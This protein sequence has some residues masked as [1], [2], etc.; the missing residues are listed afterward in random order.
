M[1]YLRKFAVNRRASN[2]VGHPT[3]L[4]GKSPGPFVPRCASSSANFILVGF[5]ARAF[6]TWLGASAF[7]RAAA[8]KSPHYKPHSSHKSGLASA[9]YMARSPP[10]AAAPLAPKLAS[11]R[12]ACLRLYRDRISLSAESGTK[13]CRAGERAASILIKSFAPNAFFWAATRPPAP[14]PPA[15]A[16]PPPSRPPLRPLPHPPLPQ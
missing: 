11:S 13:S 16:S 9:F 3:V 6:S 12:A 14:P 2:T 4:G 10:P 5:N 7:A 15:P 1:S 8:I